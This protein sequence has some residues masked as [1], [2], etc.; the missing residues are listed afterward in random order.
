M[1]NYNAISNSSPFYV[2]NIPQKQFGDFSVS[3]KI[4]LPFDK[5]VVPEHTFVVDSRQRDPTIYPSPSSYRI[6]LGT[7]YKNITSIELK[8]F[9]LFLLL[10]NV[11]STATV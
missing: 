8:G 4:T 2:P 3:E 11:S 10:N 5:I 9:L 1:Q 6:S 7:V